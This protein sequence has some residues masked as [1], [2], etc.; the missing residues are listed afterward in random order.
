M[1]V[2]RISLELFT[3]CDER[4]RLSP[5]C[6]FCLRR[7]EKGSSTV[8]VVF[9]PNPLDINLLEFEGSMET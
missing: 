7:T 3:Q 6:G 8:I 2:K 5:W 1:L 4:L 9:L